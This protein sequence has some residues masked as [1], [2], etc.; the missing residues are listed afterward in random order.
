MYYW[1][2]Y[3]KD[4]K[5]VQTLYGEIE[6]WNGLDKELKAI[7]IEENLANETI[8]DAFINIDKYI[9]KNNEVVEFTAS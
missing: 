9:I 3:N 4:G 5:I 7:R 6:E 2:L 1:F 8:K